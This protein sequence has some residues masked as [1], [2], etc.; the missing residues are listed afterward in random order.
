MA[1][2]HASKVGYNDRV[3]AKPLLVILMILVPLAGMAILKYLPLIEEQRTITSLAVL[4]AR[5]VGPP[6]YSHLE[7]DV[8]RRLTE[9]LSTKWRMVTESEADALLLTTVTVDAGIIQVGLTVVDVDTQHMLFTSPFQ[10]SRDRYDEM[11]AAAADAVKR[12]LP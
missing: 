8:P 1:P 10:S 3:R 12:S 6:D 5:F 2:V 7:R 4:P 11:I 9:L